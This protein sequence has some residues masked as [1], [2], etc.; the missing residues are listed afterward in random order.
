MDFTRYYDVSRGLYDTNEW[1]RAYLDLH[2]SLSLTKASILPQPQEEWLE[3]LSNA[4][5]DYW[6]TGELFLAKNLDMVSYCNPVEVQV[7]P[8]SSASES[9]FRFKFPDYWTRT[10]RYDPVHILN[11]VTAHS[12]RGTPPAMSQVMFLERQPM[13]QMSS[14]IFGFGT[15]E[16]NLSSANDIAEKVLSFRRKLGAALNQ[17][18][19]DLNIDFYVISPRDVLNEAKK[20]GF[21]A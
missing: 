7:G 12:L 5:L 20:F 1:Y 18:W 21:V 16:A 9:G 10:Y 8:G 17:F 15:D 14:R 19:P 6:K 2:Y 4:V 11:T 13:A 3:A